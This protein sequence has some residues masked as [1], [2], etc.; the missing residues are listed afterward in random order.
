MVSPDAYTAFINSGSKNINALRDATTPNDPN[1]T[2][3]QGA[4]LIAQ[5]GGIN[6]STTD[7]APGFNF[8]YYID[9]LNIDAVMSTKGSS[10]P[11]IAHTISFDII[12]P[13]GFSFMS[14]LK[15]AADAILKQVKASSNSSNSNAATPQNALRQHF[16]LGMKFIGYGID[17]SILTSQSSFDGGILDPSNANDDSGSVFEYFFDIKISDM[18][19][20]LDG[21][22][23]VYSFT[24]VQT[25]IKDGFGAI[26]G[27]TIDTQA[28]TANTVGSAINKLLSN[29]TKKHKAQADKGSRNIPNTYSVIWN[30]GTDIIRNATIV[31]PAD[32][33]KTKWPG[34]GAKNTK[35]SNDKTASKS[36]PN[37]KSRTIHFGNDQS[38]VQCI[39]TIIQQSSY[40]RD[41]LKVVYD[42][43]I[44][45]ND[46]TGQPN[47]QPGGNNPQISW[48]NVQPKLTNP[49][50]DTKTKTWAYD[51]A[52]V[53]SKYDT[54]ITDSVYANKKTGTNYPGPFKRYK[55]WYTGENSEVFDFAVEFNFDYYTQVMDTPDPK[56]NSKQNSDGTTSQ[57]PEDPTDVPKAPSKQTS[58][59]RTGGKGIALE[60]QNNYLTSLY[61]ATA[62]TNCKL[63][64]WGDPDYLVSAN[65]SPT[66]IV[67][68]KY[69]QNNG[70]T[71]NPTS[72]QVMVELSFL[73]AVD[74]DNS[75]G[76]MNI[77]DSIFF[78]PIPKELAQAT[79]SQ[80]N[81]AVQGIPFMIIGAKSTFASGTFKQ[82]LALQLADLSQFVGQ[83]DKQTGKSPKK[84]NS[85]HKS[86]GTRQDPPPATS[87][88]QSNPVTKKP[89]TSPAAQTEN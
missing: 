72:G 51:I 15:R 44:Q 8:D 60:T 31:S 75:T 21:K 12:E 20:K 77:N 38:L 79:D 89:I 68:Q 24:A 84:A 87:D 65:P 88:P 22:P 57:D 29:Q 83:K 54:P 61:S 34:S 39:N 18:K 48:F 11:S 81:P 47:Q 25:G 35:E 74:Y 27:T 4:F 32:L 41:A 42:S 64:I 55:Y 30:T 73:E 70:Y 82:E 62:F 53:I 17:G 78:F 45:S 3:N 9:K 19:F 40:L 14:N 16:V 56:D 10:A 80:G 23:C 7:R 59:S 66:D 2:D 1:L 71:I 67:Y 37:N 26:N 63:N 50:W 13:Y 76:V 43:E 58:E 33:D 36:K 85:T 52:Y 46:T 69:Y 6:N 49:K 28:I 86:T 5:S